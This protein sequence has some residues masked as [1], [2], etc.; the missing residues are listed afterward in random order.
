MSVT[1]PGKVSINCHYIPFDEKLA[2]IIEN[3]DPASIKT[4]PYS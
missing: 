4:S 2:N 1:P 3:I